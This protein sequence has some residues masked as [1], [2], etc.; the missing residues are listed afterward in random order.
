MNCVGQNT[1]FV[2]YSEEEVHIE[3]I[4][5]NKDFIKN[6]FDKASTF[7]T[8]GILP[9]LV[10]KWSSKAPMRHSTNVTTAST[11]TE[12]VAATPTENMEKKMFAKKEELGRYDRL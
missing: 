11:L 9:K 1:D 10:G 2:L 12:S 8:V 3:G 5:P 4:Y 6:A 7:I